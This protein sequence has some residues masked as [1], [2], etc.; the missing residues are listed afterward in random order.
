MTMAKLAPVAGLFTSLR[1]SLLSLSS[2]SN[3]FA[4]YLLLNLNPFVRLFKITRICLIS[5]DIQQHRFYAFFYAL[6]SMDKPSSDFAADRIPIV[7]EL[8]CTTPSSSG[9]TYSSLHHSLYGGVRPDPALQEKSC[10][11]HPHIA[12]T[13]TLNPPIKSC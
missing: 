9:S 5:R 13:H 2:V 6:I 10:N 4:C 12:P 1:P 11:L 8:P 7:V 3:R